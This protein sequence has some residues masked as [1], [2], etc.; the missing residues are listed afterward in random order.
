MVLTKWRSPGG[1]IARMERRMRRLFEEPFGLELFT[2]DAGW[3][4]AV[5]VKDIDNELMVTVELPGMMVE[6]VEVNLENNVLTIR[7]EKKEEKEEKEQ[8]RYVYERYY[9]AFQRSF[10]LPSP[11]DESRVKAE[12]T[13]GVLAI[14][15]PKTEQTKGRKI[16]ITQ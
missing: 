2:E 4:P 15:L 13:N 5:E 16:E 7:G 10:T 9:G 8:E 3:S 14:H 6:D 11:V 1:E 12:F